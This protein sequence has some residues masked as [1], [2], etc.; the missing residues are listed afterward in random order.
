MPPRNTIS[1]FFVGD[2][3]SNI[4]VTIVHPDAVGIQNPYSV[5]KNF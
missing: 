4:D 3:G 1:G 2:I 5:I